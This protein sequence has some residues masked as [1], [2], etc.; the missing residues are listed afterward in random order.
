M[1]SVPVTAST[2]PSP[3]LKRW[4][5]RWS[6]PRSSSGVHSG[7]WLRINW[8]LLNAPL[9]WA[10]GCCAIGWMP[11]QLEGERGQCQHARAE[12]A[13]GLGGVAG[14]V[15]G[16]ELLALG[17]CGSER[18]RIGRAEPQHGDGNARPPVLA[19]V[20]GAHEG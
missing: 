8:L 2:L 20:L 14:G 19:E 3:I 18:V 16:W 5:Y 1:P 10:V 11:E 13:L 4:R 17:L 12:R 9:G 6:P 15:D 7:P